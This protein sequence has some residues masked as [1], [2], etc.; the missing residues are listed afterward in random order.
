[1]SALTTASCNFTAVAR[2]AALLHGIGLFFTKA[3]LQS[4]LGALD[5][6]L[7]RRSCS[8]WLGAAC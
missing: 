6:S 5:S 7:Q 4:Q 3:Q 8:Q 1:M 2:M